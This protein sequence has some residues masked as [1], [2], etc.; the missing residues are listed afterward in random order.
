MGLVAVAC[1]ADGSVSTDAQ[2][3]STTTT[4]TVPTSAVSTPIV[5]PAPHLGGVNGPVVF[6]APSEGGE[7]ALLAG[8]EIALVDGC[9]G[10]GPPSNFTA[11][12][13][14][15]GS[16]WDDTTSTLTLADGSSFTPD[17]SIDLG[18]GYTSEPHR[19]A[20][21][22][23]AEAQFNRCATLSEGSTFWSWQVGPAAPPDPDD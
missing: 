4:S 19:N 12:V 8:G 7:E 9:L 18:G 23:E 22:G 1:G 2:S 21:D 11:I 20:L 14:P 3:A 17:D 10:L 16:V 6:A 15:H 5:E 13:W